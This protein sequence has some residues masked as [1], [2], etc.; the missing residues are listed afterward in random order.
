VNQLQVTATFPRIA[1]DN[2]SEFKGMV[3]EA[4]RH[5][6]DEPGVLQYDWF[7]NDDQTKWVARESYADSDAVLTHLGLVGHLLGRM[8]ELGGGVQIELFGSPSKALVEAL[9][10]VQPAIYSYFQGKSR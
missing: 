9:E 3:D 2:L 8:T 5:V 7:S 6:A 10:A 4:L 1:S